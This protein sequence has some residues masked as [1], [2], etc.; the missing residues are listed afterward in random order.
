MRTTVTLIV[1]PRNSSSA[2]EVTGAVLLLTHLRYKRICPFFFGVFGFCFLKSSA[3]RLK[4][5]GRFDALCG[6]VPSLDS[7]S[8]R[9]PNDLDF[10]FLSFMLPLLCALSLKMRFTRVKRGR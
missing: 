6:F 7:R 5:H 4:L 10:P 9:F 8:V 1:L 2:S 3:V